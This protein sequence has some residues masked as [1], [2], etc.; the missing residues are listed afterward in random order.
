MN[1]ENS[2]LKNFESFFKYI[3]DNY[4]NDLPFG[5]KIWQIPIGKPKQI[6][7]ENQLRVT[8]YNGNRN[9]VRFIT[10]NQDSKFIDE[11]K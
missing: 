9:D 10:H 11:M 2:P 4:S 8:N 6:K 3:N 1:I 5:N 7:S